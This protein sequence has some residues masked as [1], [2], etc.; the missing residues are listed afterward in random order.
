MSF[1]VG[2]TLLSE[3][4]ALEIKGE[5]DEADPLWI[6]A[7]VLMILGA[8]Y[9]G[10]LAVQAGQCCM[11]RLQVWLSSPSMP[12]GEMQASSTS[13]ATK[14]DGENDVEKRSS[15]RRRLNASSGSGPVQAFGSS[16]PVQASGASSSGAGT[17]G[18][19]QA[20]GASSSGAG[21][22]GPVQASG[23]SSSGTGNVGPVQA[24]AMMPSS[25]AGTLSSSSLVQALSTGSMSFG[26]VQATGASS[27]SAGS[28]GPVQ[29]FGASSNAAA[30]ISPSAG[31]GP[32]QPFAAADP[33]PEQA[34]AADVSGLEQALRAVAEISSAAAADGVS[35]ESA[36]Q[37][38]AAGV[39]E[40]LLGGERSEMT[41]HNPWN[42]FQHEHRGKGWSPAK[43]RRCTRNGKATPER[44][45]CLEPTF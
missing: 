2:Q 17:Y 31:S 18:P 15:L 39:S 45:K 21:N 26:P 20:S 19:V 10:K 35:V 34:F 13:S 30:G 3:A 41:L 1:L 28:V 29:A 33:G 23:A 36:L 43:C 37:R 32:E 12:S 38:H 6:A 24:P 5:Q 7:V 25:G 9:A 11:R 8:I 14:D 44:I 40:A 27:C 42:L 16:G 4:E 22:Y